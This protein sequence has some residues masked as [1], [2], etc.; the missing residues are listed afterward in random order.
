MGAEAYDV[1]ERRM[2]KEEK[3]TSFLQRL[4][5]DRKNTCYMQKR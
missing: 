1:A 4:N 2:C 5:H 3:G